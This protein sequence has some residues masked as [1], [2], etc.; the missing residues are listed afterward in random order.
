MMDGLSS[1]VERV[2]CQVI[3][4]HRVEITPDEFRQ[5]IAD[6]PD[7]TVLDWDYLISITERLYLF[8]LWVSDIGTVPTFISAITQ[9]NGEDQAPYDER[10]FDETGQNQ[11]LTEQSY[12]PTPPETADFPCRL[13]FFLHFVDLDADLVVADKQQELPNP[14]PMPELLKKIMPYQ[15]PN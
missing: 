11:L 7:Y 15:P 1:R 6:D 4:L 8:D 14:S 13:R 12:M 10:Y 2:K 5:K 9:D 3:A